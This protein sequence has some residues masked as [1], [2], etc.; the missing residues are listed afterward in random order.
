[1][2][3]YCLLSSDGRY[4][5]HVFSKEVD[6][7]NVIAKHV[8]QIFGENIIYI[9]TKKKL[10][11][12]ELGIASIPDGFLL[13]L[14]IPDDVTLY[15]IEVELSTHDPRDV[16]KQILSFEL[17][18]QS[19][20]DEIY[21][22][23][24]EEIKN[25]QER[26][27]VINQ[28]LR[29]SSVYRDLSSL[30]YQVVYE[31][32]H[33]YLII[34]DRITELLEKALSLLDINTRIFEFITFVND[35]GRYAYLFQDFRGEVDQVSMRQE[36][37][38]LETWYD[39]YLEDIEEPNI[40]KESFL[41]EKKISNPPQ[42]YTYT[43]SENGEIDGIVFQGYSSRLDRDL[44]RYRETGEFSWGTRKP[45][46]LSNLHKGMWVY[47]VETNIDG[48]TGKQVERPK[49]R[50]KGRLKEVYKVRGKK[51]EKIFPP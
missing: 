10:T 13:D 47:V 32:E 26:L 2:F 21:K 34:I 9:N 15:I 19:S 8:T 49:L 27:K 23:L 45:I 41:N 51:K 3:D 36:H 7:E 1:M 25:D 37:E 16:V 28:T 17:S 35:E 5:R 20:L 38:P 46:K 4:R 24:L 14:S 33:Q 12:K 39:I 42:A 44:A 30:I 11:A 50:V 43:R 22:F 6:F 48:D 18:Y 40:D 31:Q 29:K